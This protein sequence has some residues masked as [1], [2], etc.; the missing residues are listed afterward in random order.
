MLLLL[1]L[2]AVVVVVGAAIFFLAAMAEGGGATSTPSDGEPAAPSFSDEEEGAV[3]ALGPGVAFLAGC[4]AG[5]A[6]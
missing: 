6:C 3:G 4:C 1:L 2:L 5:E